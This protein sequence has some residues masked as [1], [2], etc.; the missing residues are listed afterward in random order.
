VVVLKV[1]KTSGIDFVYGRRFKINRR[2]FKVKIW[3][4]GYP[5]PFSGPSLKVGAQVSNPLNPLNP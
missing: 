3:Q 2:G 4:T 5:M 1:A